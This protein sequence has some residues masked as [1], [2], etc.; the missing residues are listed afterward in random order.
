MQI[1]NK[2]KH[3]KHKKKGDNNGW[4]WRSEEVGKSELQ[5]VLLDP[6]TLTFFYS[7]PNDVF[8]LLQFTE[9]V[10]YKTNPDF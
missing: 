3:I 9:W 5:L 1:S 6:A 8:H 7:S 2:R 10:K 4:V